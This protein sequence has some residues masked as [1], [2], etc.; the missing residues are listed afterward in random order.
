ME[1]KYDT[2]EEEHIRNEKMIFDAIIE[3]NRHGDGDGDGDDIQYAHPYHADPYHS[4]KNSQKKYDTEEEDHIRNE[5]MKFHTEE[6]D[7]I[8]NEKMKLKFYTEEEDIRNEKMKFGTLFED[9]TL[10]YKDDDAHPYHW[11]EEIHPRRPLWRRNLWRTCLW[12]NWTCFD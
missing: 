3:D 6:D 11:E 10:Y 4:Y 5:K 12:R 8:R 2:E 1:K 7:H 9:D